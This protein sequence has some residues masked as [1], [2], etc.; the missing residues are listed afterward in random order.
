MAHAYVSILTPAARAQVLTTVLEST[1][2]MARAPKVVPV[3]CVP[4]KA[5]T[6]GWTRLPVSAQPSSV[7]AELP[8]A[9]T[10]VL[11]SVAATRVAVLLGT[12]AITVKYG[13]LATVLSALTVQ[14]AAIIPIMAA[15]SSAIAITVTMVVTVDYRDVSTRRHVIMAVN[16]LKA[17]AFARQNG[18]EA[19]ARKRFP[20]FAKITIAAKAERAVELH[21]P[22]V[23][24]R[25]DINR[26]VHLI[27]AN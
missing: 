23:P 21:L 13:I 8:F 19:R 10:R 16:V 3:T 9:D 24:V 26:P 14:R 2:F 11:V 15:I 17:A 5:Q 6:S 12:Q 1:V 7:P 27:L 25:L 22:Y 20:T 4:A 18:P